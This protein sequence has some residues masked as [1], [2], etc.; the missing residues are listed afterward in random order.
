MLQW[1]VYEGLHPD[2]AKQQVP[3]AVPCL[4]GTVYFIC[5]FFLSLKKPSAPSPL[6]QLVPDLLIFTPRWK[7]KKKKKTFFSFLWQWPATAHTSGSWLNI[8][9]LYHVSQCIYWETYHASNEDHC[10]HFSPL[11]KCLWKL[12]P[13][14]SVVAVF[15][16]ICPV[17]SSRGMVSLALSAA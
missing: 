5:Y 12:A 10:K 14:N 9:Y 13:R 7:K 8:R 17:Y 6:L 16:H 4:Q 3:A 11:E 2:G 1:E 15:Y